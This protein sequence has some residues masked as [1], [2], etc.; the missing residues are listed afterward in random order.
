M[1]SLLSCAGAQADTAPK[2][3]I[4]TYA[5]HLR[6]LTSMHAARAD[7]LDSFV[8]NSLRLR[9]HCAA[10]MLVYAV[11]IAYFELG[12]HA[13]QIPESANPTRARHSPRILPQ[14]TEL[15]PFCATTMRSTL[16]FVQLIGCACTIALDADKSFHDRV[17]AALFGIG[18]FSR[19]HAAPRPPR[20]A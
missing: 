3:S 18:P 14:D 9:W 2:S 13:L 15:W 17:Y 6:T 10:Y 8:A 5:T 16:A 1:T 12:S 7:A 11:V 20:P 19:N 4:K